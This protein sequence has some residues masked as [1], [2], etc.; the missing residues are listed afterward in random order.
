M[1]GLLDKFKKNKV[2][3][4]QVSKV[5][6]ARASI[7]QGKGVSTAQVIDVLNIDC[8][9]KDPSN[10]VVWSPQTLEKLKTYDDHKSR[11]I[12]NAVQEKYSNENNV[13]QMKK[14]FEFYKTNESLFWENLE[15][16]W[17]Y[18]DFGVS[19]N[20]VIVLDVCENQL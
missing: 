6:A 13:E 4:T 19:P 11:A 15:N 16:R 10:F 1:F 14:Q 20:T 5:S 9:N 12:I 18:M 2:E 3:K 17:I 7:K 8:E